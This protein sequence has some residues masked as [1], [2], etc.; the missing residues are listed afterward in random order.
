LP[1]Q[2]TRRE[3]PHGPT[4]AD[5]DEGTGDTHHR[6]D[7]AAGFAHRKAVRARKECR[8]PPEQAAAGKCK[9][10][11]ADQQVEYRPV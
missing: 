11:A 7:E 5:H 6:A 4:G 2:I 9:Y 1:P 8:R 10:R 3:P